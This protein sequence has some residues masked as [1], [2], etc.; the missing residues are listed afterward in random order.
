VA[1]LFLVK[2]VRALAVFAILLFGGCATSSE[3]DLLYNYYFPRH[4]EYVTTR[5]RGCYDRLLFAP[6]QAAGSGRPADH[7]LYF[8]FHGD[9]TALNQ[10]V[11]DPDRS[12]EG[13]FGE[14]W[15]YDCVVLL[16]RLGDDR[17]AELLRSEDRDTRE[18]VG[19][20]ID[21]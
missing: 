21:S 8:G 6:P 20:A 3:F 11:H 19:V 10:F 5:Y 17:F 9:V 4:S 14:S 15:V 16:L 18:A 12:G 2:R 13:E 1:Y 7:K